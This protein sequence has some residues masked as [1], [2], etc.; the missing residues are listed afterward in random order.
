MQRVTFLSKYY[1]QLI[2]GWAYTMMAISY[3]FIANDNTFTQ[4]IQLPSFKTDVVFALSVTYCMG[5][6]LHRLSGKLDEEISK[7][8]FLLRLKQQALKGIVLPLILATG[9]EM[10]YLLLIDIPIVQ[11]GM[12]NLETPLT[13]LF[14]MIVNFLYLG[15]KLYL[16]TKN[17]VQQDVFQEEAPVPMQFL[18]VQRGYKE[19]KIKIEDCAFIKSTNKQ[20][21][22]YTLDGKEMRLKGTLE[23][24]E[25]QLSPTFFRLNRQYLATLNA[26]QTIAQT[27]TRKLKVKFCIEHEDDVYISKENAPHFRKWWKQDCPL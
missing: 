17:G 1:P 7:E 22:L 24:W 11:S 2:V 12:F 6:Y 21:L 25:R 27:E 26:I 8:D 3:I 19:E 9:L 20:L 13:L 18:V 23:E 4:V 10:G 14:L 16:T 15:R 5:I